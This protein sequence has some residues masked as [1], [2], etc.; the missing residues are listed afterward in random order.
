MSGSASAACRLPRISVVTICKNAVDTIGR[1]LASVA[2]NAYPALEYVVVDGGS[3][4]GTLELIRRYGSHVSKLV[5]EPDRGISDALNKAVALTESDYHIVVHADDQM[6]PNALMRLGEVASRSTAQVICGAVAVASEGKV[7]RIFKPEPEKLS[8]KMSVPHMGALI[9][10]D[11]WRA[12]G[13]YDLR[14]RI[15]MDHLLMLRIGRRFGLSAFETVDQVVARYSLGGVSDRHV[16]RGFRELRE[17]LLEEGVGRAAAEIAYG[18]LLV[19][20]RIA[21]LVGRG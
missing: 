16:I 11:A 5:S 13:G 18:K 9:R 12:V 4:D 21:R 6:L 14:R 17:N 8:E 19:K 7:V 1:A 2:D 20:S 10:K 15:A 3:T